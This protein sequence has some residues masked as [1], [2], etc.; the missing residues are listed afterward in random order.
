MEEKNKK[1][2][3]K[4]KLLILSLGFFLFFSPA[5]AAD[6]TFSPLSGSYDVGKSFSVNVIV[7]SPG[8][9]INAI[10]G[11]VS[12]SDNLE[13]A[14]LS[15]SGS[16]IKLWAQDPFYSNATKTVNFEGIIFNPGFSGPSGKVITIGFKAKN[17][18][19]G[20]I[21]FSSASVLAND[22]KGT[23]VLNNL[24][25]ASFNIN[26][27]T[28]VEAEKPLINEAGPEAPN[29]LSSTHPDSKKWYSDNNPNFSWSLPSGIT[30]VNVLIDKNSQ[31]DPG[32]R[33]DGLFASYKYS[34]INDGEWYFHIRL[35]NSSGWGKISH[36][37]FR[38]DSKKPEVFEI[39]ENVRNN[40]NIPQISLILNAVD[41]GSGIDYYLIKIDD[42]IEQKWK[43][44]G[45][46]IYITP[47]LSLGKHLL[48]AKAFDL[49][50]NYSESS[51]E[52]NV[53]AIT[54]P[55]IDGHQVFQTEGS[56][57][58]ITGSSIPDSQVI[59]WVKIDSREP[60]S[61]TI[62]SDNN[63]RYY[64]TLKEKLKYGIYGISVEAFDQEGSRSKSTNVIVIVSKPITWQ[65]LILSIVSELLVKI[66]LYLL[67]TSILLLIIFYVLYLS[68]RHRRIIKNNKVKNFLK[69]NIKNIKS[70]E[71]I[72]NRRCLKKEEIIL[73]DIM[74][75]DLIEFREILAEGKNKKA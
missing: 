9:A 40:P 10:S 55:T 58:T 75:K 2:I 45:D 32:T 6:L 74:K 22:G 53:G 11:V 25:I 48:L 50:G 56:I 70:L 43:D 44:S 49:A 54:S 71:E 69:E 59:V 51:I 67:L 42:G 16:I 37:L 63:G 5:Y 19:I 57:L 34:H 1:I 24:G 28:V 36:F 66:C 72:K 60:K 23:N 7:S 14:E 38:V 68:R 41:S 21:I 31:T 4:F 15:Q 27:S 65:S 46:H 18:G 30:D 73:L 26:K 47:L 20:R 33:S 13:V 12:F 3:N 29:I 61:Y 39:K 17:S 52:L 35:K 64:F 8:Q 62:K